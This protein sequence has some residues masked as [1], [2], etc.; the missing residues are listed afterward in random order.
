MYLYDATQ[1][2]EHVRE[3]KKQISEAQ[4]R[5]GLFSDRDEQKEQIAKLEEELD[6]LF[7][8]RQWIAGRVDQIL[9]VC[10]GDKSQRRDVFNDDVLIGRKSTKKPSQLLRS[11]S[12][13]HARFRPGH[14]L[15]MWVDRLARAGFLTLEAS[16]TINLDAPD[17]P[18]AV[19]RRALRIARARARKHFRQAIK[20]DALEYTGGDQLRTQ[21]GLKLALAHCRHLETS[22]PPELFENWTQEAARRDVLPITLQTAVGAALYVGKHYE[23]IVDEHLA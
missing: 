1:F 21:N 6:D 23:R 9:A 19:K 22:S 15:K 5:K 20:D 17:L 8:I 7:A 4:K 11:L 12:E 3:L 10:G 18:S 14:V 13:Q 16:K 2:N